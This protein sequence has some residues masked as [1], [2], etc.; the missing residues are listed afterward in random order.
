MNHYYT[1]DLM[2]KE[3]FLSKKWNN[4]LTISLGLPT[5]TLGIAGF[6]AP[7]FSDFRDFIMMAVLA[8]VY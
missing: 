4:I 1:G 7:L 5:V 2:N 6:N 3:L 8:G